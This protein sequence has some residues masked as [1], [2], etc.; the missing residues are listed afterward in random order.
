MTGH[1]HAVAAQLQMP[2]P[3]GLHQMQ[4]LEAQ[5]RLQLPASDLFQPGLVASLLQLSAGTETASSTLV[6]H[7]HSSQ[8]L[9]A[10]L[11]LGFGGTKACS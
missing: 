2:R 9:T 11:A 10:G 7:L 5:T 4:A 1:C 3:Q 6:P 8:S